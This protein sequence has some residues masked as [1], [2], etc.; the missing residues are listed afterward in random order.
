MAVPHADGSKELLEAQ[1][2]VWNHTFNYITAMS[3]KCAVQLGI[4]DIISNNEEPV[5]LSKLVHELSIPQERS[6]HVYRLMRI[7]V[8]SGFFSMQIYKDQETYALTAS[9]KLLLKNHESN[10]SPFL[11]MILDPFMVTPLHFLSDWFRGSKTSAFET[12]HG[13]KIWDYCGIHSDANTLFNDALASDSELVM[14]VVLR[15]YKAMFEGYASL[16][17]VG[18]G[19]GTV[20]RAFSNVFPLMRCTVYDLPHVV[21]GMQGSKNLEFVAGDMFES[22]PS[23]DIVLLKWILHDWGDK[24]CVKI[25]KKCR[26]AI[27]S[28]ERGGKVIII[29]M[30]I[31]EKK[32][33][34]EH[35]E[36]QICIDMLLM[37]SFTGKERAENQWEILFKQAGFASYKI[38]HGLGLRSIIEVF[39]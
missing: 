6:L 33:T 27:S 25:L 18:G 26:D 3:L 12:S 35:F 8:H 19:T 2:H 4:P 17:D 16:T 13:M 14:N 29:D 36:T 32:G 10:L 9:S 21:S 28:N 5:T 11:L 34:Y 20:A 1:A 31:D 22:V 37:A 15:D 24:E 38:T 23:A 7:L 30:V 39:P